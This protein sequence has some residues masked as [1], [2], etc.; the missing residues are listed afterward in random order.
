MAIWVSSP[1][2]QL[3]SET[4]DKGTK[5]FV[6]LMAALLVLGRKVLRCHIGFHMEVL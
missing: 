1:D 6:L 5:V 3:L 4:P 2:F